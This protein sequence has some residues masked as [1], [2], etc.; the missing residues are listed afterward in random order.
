MAGLQGKLE[1]LVDTDDLLQ[2]EDIDLATARINSASQPKQAAADVIMSMEGLSA[3]ER[4]RL[5]RKAK[6]MNRTD[7]LR[8]A[9]SLNLPRTG[10]M[11]PP[12]GGGASSDAQGPSDAAVTDEVVWADVSAGGW[13]LQYAA[14][15]M[16]VDLLDPV[17]EVRHGAAVGLRELLR[18]AAGSAG[19]Q[20]P[21]ADETSGW[22]MAGGTGT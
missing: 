3:R 2:N 6:A 9:D 16:V 4:N 1:T 20:E 22:M 8:N 10:S 15:Q 21:V 7:S 14:D 12:S 19:F 11:R 13:V 17:W 5:K 18:C